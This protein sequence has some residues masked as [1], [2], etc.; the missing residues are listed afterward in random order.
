MRGHGLPERI[1]PGG[2]TEEHGVAAAQ[3]LLSGPEALPTA[4]VAFNDRCAV[5]V[6]DTLSRAGVSVPGDVS[7]VGYDDDRL[8]RHLNLTTVA[9]NAP[10]IAAQAVDTAVARLDG[11][12]CASHETVIPPQLTLRGTTGP[13]A[14]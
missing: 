12:E 7:L 11:A 4:V 2:L 9:Q 3:T 5:G 13:P 8:S 1:R 10:R 14:G 6:L